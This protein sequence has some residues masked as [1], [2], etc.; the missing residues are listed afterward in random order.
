M[1]SKPKEVVVGPMAQLVQSASGQLQ[2]ERKEG[3][4]LNIKFK[5]FPVQPIHYA[6]IGKVVAGLA[7][8][9]SAAHAEL[10]QP[11]GRKEKK[12]REKRKDKKGRKKRGRID[13]VFHPLMF[14]VVYQ[15]RGKELFRQ[16][17]CRSTRIHWQVNEEPSNA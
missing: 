4:E 17:E 11:E 13:S 6:Q 3:K 12:K 2:V 7:G 14:L 15:T 8:F 9:A 1:Q 10:G 5:L 16:F